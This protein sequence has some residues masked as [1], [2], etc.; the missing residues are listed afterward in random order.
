MNTT[1]VEPAYS[2]VALVG[3]FLSIYVMQKT[4]FDHVNQVD[5]PVLQ[6]VRR[7]AFV[8]VAAA[9]CYSVWCPWRP[10]VIVLL[11]VSAG[12]GNLIVNALAL[13]M[14]GRPKDRQGM[15]RSPERVPARRW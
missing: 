1:W 14:R 6:W 2:V 4:E 12:V 5:H 8:I 9:L 11:L 3:A 15:E 10:S 7:F 13:H